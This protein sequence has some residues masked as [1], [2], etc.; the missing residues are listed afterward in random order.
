MALAASPPS[1]ALDHLSVSDLENLLDPVT[2]KSGNALTFRNWA[3]T[4]RSDA[5]AVFRPRSVQQVRYAVE[6]ARRQKR[7]I[8]AAGAGHSPSDIVC[9][10][11][12]ILDL[13]GLNNVIDVDADD[14]TFHAE[15]G[16]LLRNLHPILLERG[17]LAL[18]SLGSIS[19]QTLAGALSTSTHGSG[20][21]FASISTYATFLDIVLPQPNAPVV[22]V[23]RQADQ[24]PDLFHSALCGLGAVGIVVGVGMRAERVFKLE[25]EI[26]TMRFNDFTARWQ[27]IAESAEHVR[28]W[29][30]PQVA[31]VKVSR[32]NRTDKAITPRPSAVSSY[33]QNVVLA[34]HIHAI[35]L[36]A[37]RYFP[38]L[39]PYHAWFMWTFREQPGPVRWR[40]FL[41]GI[42]TR[43]SGSK[44]GGPWPRIAD[45]QE[46]DQDAASTSE[47]AQ[48]AAIGET[49]TTSATLPFHPVDPTTLPQLDASLQKV[50]DKDQTSKA[51]EADMLTPPYTPATR[52][53]TGS[54]EPVRPD[55]PSSELELPTCVLG[56]EEHSVKV[57]TAGRSKLPWPILEEEPTYRVDLGVNI[58]NYDCGFPQY[59]YESCIPYE[60]TGSALSKLHNWHT[61]ELAKPGYPLRAHF[62]VEIR[63]AAKDEAWLSPTGSGPGCYLGAIQYRPFNLPVPYRD[64]FARFSSTLFS[65]F[66]GKPH[67]AKTHT[68]T[69]ADLRK[70][71]PRFDDFLAVR[72]RVDPER[73]LANEYVK[74]HLLGEVPTEQMEHQGR[75]WKE[76]A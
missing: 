22:R 76:R 6:L 67:W 31:R 46:E 17:Q 27:E 18:S 44:T 55:S 19:D 58:F 3:T 69:P 45:L 25:E 38:A 30:F 74:R 62:P 32:L 48:S 65:L 72:E 75:R 12:Y 43:L 8:R 66:S 10:G 60:L 42:W 73:V 24:D 9:T 37:A 59:T 26:F 39:L 61:H 2:V 21:T 7:T 13:K 54:A 35:A 71:Y 4:F 47:D 34:K 29:W 70:L 28:C 33:L 41:G 57:S 49:S 15:G 50:A 63:Y 68:L 64:H 53:P 52:S 36:S 16:I 40:D 20:V 14:K 23:S 51:P 5:T 11:D 1:E 56:S